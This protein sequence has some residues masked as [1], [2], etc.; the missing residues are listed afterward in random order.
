MCKTTTANAL[1]L[2]EYIDSINDFYFIEPEPCPYKDHIGAIFTDSIL[3]A[4]LNYRKVVWPR[5]RNVLETYPYADTVHTFAEVLNH[6]GTSNILR[7]N[8]KEKIRRM[9]E[10]VSFCL[11]NNIDNTRQLTDYLKYDSNISNLKSIHGIGDKTCDYMKRLLGFDTVAVDR[12]VRAFIESAD[13]FCQEY[14]DIKEIVAFTADFMD[15]ARRELD[16]S[17]WS[18]MSQKEKRQIQLLFDF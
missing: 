13:I 8:N 16:Y 14:E 12:H 5:V 6:F 2:K 3:Q 4:G 9:E 10:L 1:R 7:W 11:D 18:Y 17:I 15:C